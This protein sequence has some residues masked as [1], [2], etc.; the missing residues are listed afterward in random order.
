MEGVG[1]A[2]FEAEGHS[3]VLP[4]D[5]KCVGMVRHFRANLGKLSDG[6]PFPLRLP[7]L[8]PLFHGIRH[9]LAGRNHHALIDA[10]DT[11]NVLELHYFAKICRR[12]IR[13]L[14]V[15]MMEEFFRSLF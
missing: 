8:F 4:P 12:C 11:L 1:E 6:T 9:E 14:A 3:D 13:V 10:T 5:S 15:Q 7:I 2:W